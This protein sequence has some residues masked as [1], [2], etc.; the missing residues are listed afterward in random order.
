M[1]CDKSSF[2]KQV[3]WEL[4][5]AKEKGTFGHS[6]HKL[7]NITEPLNFYPSEDSSAL[8]IIDLVLYI[9]QRCQHYPQDEHPK[10]RKSRE[11]LWKIIDPH[12]LVDAI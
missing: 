9:W 11:K 2:A 1:V 8:Q 12:V 7:S 10:A 3:S 5:I 6:P 4:S